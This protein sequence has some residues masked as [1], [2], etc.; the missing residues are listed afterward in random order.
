MFLLVGDKLLWMWW[1]FI[2]KAEDLFFLTWNEVCMV[3]WGVLGGVAVSVLYSRLLGILFEG[4]QYL[5]LSSFSFSFASCFSFV[6]NCC[7]LEDLFVCV[8]G[9][10]FAAV[11]FLVDL[12]V[13]LFA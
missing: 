12:E 13:F 5:F 6:G 8:F 10:G 4:L 3:L 2:F 7:M 1:Q 11:V 9:A